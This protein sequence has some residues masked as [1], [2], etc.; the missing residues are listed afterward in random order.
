MHQ[1]KMDVFRTLLLFQNLWCLLL[2]NLRYLIG[3][4]SRLR[5]QQCL[6]KFNEERPELYYMYP[7]T[8]LVSSPPDLH[9]TQHVPPTSRCTCHSPAPR[10]THMGKQLTPIPM[11]NFAART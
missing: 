9:Y 3:L 10:C 4:H 6:N 11:P 2:Q 8:S 1:R 5:N 7:P